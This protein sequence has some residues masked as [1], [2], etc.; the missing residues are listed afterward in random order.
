MTLSN[1]SYGLT[2]HEF[3]FQFMGITMTVPKDSTFDV[4]LPNY[5][6]EIYNVEGFVRKE[7]NLKGLLIS[8]ESGDSATVKVFAL[9]NFLRINTH[10]SLTLNLYLDGGNTIKQ[11]T[12][13][14]IGAFVSGI[15]YTRPKDL[16]FSFN[17][18]IEGSSW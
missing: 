11:Y 3:L 16:Q 12:G 7:V 15:S 5:T 18:V 4:D 1:I 6:A 9:A 13:K 8:D 14:Y 17:F 2:S 10:N